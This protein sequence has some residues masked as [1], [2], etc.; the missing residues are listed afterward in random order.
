M[1]KLGIVVGEKGTARHLAT[2]LASLFPGLTELT[3][4]AVGHYGTPDAHSFPSEGSNDF[5]IGPDY[6]HA[7]A[8]TYFNMRKT[9]IYGG[10]NEIQRNIITKMI[11]GL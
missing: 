2:T 10:S 11:L 9:S 6:A 5:P 3:L 4:E 7:A 1:K 8:P